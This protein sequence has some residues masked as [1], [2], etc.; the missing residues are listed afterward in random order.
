M[1]NACWRCCAHVFGVEDGVSA[2]LCM[3]MVLQQLA[4]SLADPFYPTLAMDRGA[5]QVMVGVV[6]STFPLCMMLGR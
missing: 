4:F 1:A 2:I 3:V 6:F 5:S